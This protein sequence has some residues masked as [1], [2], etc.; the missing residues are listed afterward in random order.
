MDIGAQLRSAR[1]GK[2][3]S[4]GTV[5][6]RI[7]VPVKTLAAIERNDQS[8]LPPHPFGRG[9]VRAYADE[10]DLDADR[11]VREYFAQFPSPPPVPNHAP[12]SREPVEPLW[13]PPSRW[14]GMAT[15]VAVLLVV[16]A[17]AVVLGR[18]SERA[19]AT[20]D[21]RHDGHVHGHAWNGR[22]RTSKLQD[23]RTE[24]PQHTGDRATAHRSPSPSS[25]RSRARAG[26]PQPR[27][28]S[29]CSIESC[30]PASAT[31]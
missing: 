30:S 28:A 22:S 24:P 3:L 14:V 29:V 13:Q 11:L 19:P 18:R 9:F 16:V 10:V 23:A 6:E 15:A 5:A 27:M 2:D 4:I 7:R 21:R 20:R 8:A 31:R 25:C 1:E 12:L 17:A 26:S